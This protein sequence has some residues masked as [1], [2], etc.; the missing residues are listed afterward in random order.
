MTFWLIEGFA[1]AVFI[2]GGSLIVWA[3]NPREEKVPGKHRKARKWFT[4]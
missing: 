2:L 3:T 4:R 1:G